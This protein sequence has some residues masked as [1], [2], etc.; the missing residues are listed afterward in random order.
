MSRGITVGFVAAGL[1]NVVGILVFSRGLTTDALGQ[2]F[3]EVFGRFGCVGVFLWGLAYLAVARRP[4]AVP[5]ILL[6]FAVEKA[7]Y[8]A[9]W[10]YW[11][12]VRS[13]GYSELWAAD[14]L[15]ALFYTIYGPNDFA[16]GVFFAVCWW[17]FR[18]VGTPE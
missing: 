15:T 16:F 4:A 7:V 2:P 3:P 12:A 9:S 10:V 11:L 1:M 5:A 8:S 13:G 6:V 14:P 17:R 18:M